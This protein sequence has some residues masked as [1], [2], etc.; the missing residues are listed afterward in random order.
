MKH[1]LGPLIRGVLL[2]VLAPTQIQKCLEVWINFNSDKTF[3]FMFILRI[4]LCLIK[5]F[6]YFHVT[7]K[8]TAVVNY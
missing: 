6:T 8:Q 7:F 3:S 5:I 1:L 4:C 2:H